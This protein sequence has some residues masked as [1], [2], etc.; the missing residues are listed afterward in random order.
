MNTTHI[1]ES[2]HKTQ[3]NY[4]LLCPE[5]LL[6]NIA[7]GAKKNSIDLLSEPLDPALEKTKA[8][9]TAC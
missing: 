1:C 9:F 6:A 4:K 3:Q 7:L 8:H 5:P 2:L